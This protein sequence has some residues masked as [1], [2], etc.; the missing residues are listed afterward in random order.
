RVVSGALRD[1]DVVGFHREG[2]SVEIAV[3]HVRQGKLLGRRTFSFT[4]QEFPDEEIVSSF[5][6]LYYDLGSYVPDEVLLPCPIEDAETKAE[7][8]REKRSGSGQKGRSRVV[9]VLAPQRGARAKLVELA[10][11]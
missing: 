5:V 6:S 8:L 7:W 11:K 9:E 1:Q 3:L 10:T 2:A 4:G